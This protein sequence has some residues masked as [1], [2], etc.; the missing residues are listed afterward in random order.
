M[1]AAV[2]WDHCAARCLRR[3]CSDA[4]E[5]RRKFGCDGGGSY[6][7]DCWRCTRT[8][9][10]DC[11]LCHGSG[12]VEFEWCPAHHVTVEVAQVHEAYHHYR[13]GFLPAPGGSS[14]QSATFMVAVRM[15]A[16]MYAL[17][18]KREMNA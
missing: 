3:G 12:E 8:V 1:A 15:L 17:H 4:P 14:D 2:A 10:R 13:N 6:F 5:V 11:S 18:E 16:G 9:N 7:L